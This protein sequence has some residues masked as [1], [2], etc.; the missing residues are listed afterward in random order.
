IMK[1]P[2]VEYMDIVDAT[3]EGSA[4]PVDKCTTTGHFIKLMNEVLDITY[5][6]ED[7]KN[8]YLDM[9][10]CTILKTKP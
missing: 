7:F 5:H 9:D 6:D 2:T 1:E 3:A 8:H 10:N 4:A